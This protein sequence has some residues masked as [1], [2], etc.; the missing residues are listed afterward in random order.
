MERR[1]TPEIAGAPLT[2]M[3][4]PWK[5]NLALCPFIAMTPCE[6][7]AAEA[8]QVCPVAPM[9]VLRR[10]SSERSS[11]IDARGW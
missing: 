4:T 11:C 10:T 8:S 9:S 2:S 7:A 6:A 1:K 5:T 3:W